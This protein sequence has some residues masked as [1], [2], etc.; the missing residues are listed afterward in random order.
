MP[1]RPLN[2]DVAAA[3]ADEWGDTLFSTR[4]RDNVS[5]AE[6]PSNG[7]DVFSHK[8]AVTAQK[9][10][11]AFAAEFLEKGRRDAMGLR[12]RGKNQVKKGS[13]SRLFARTEPG[14]TEEIQ[15]PINTGIQ[16]PLPEKK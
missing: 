16:E 9:D 11:A 6:A 4:I 3:L 13:P 1:E 10:Y 2:K 5:L 8:E 12:D 14:I 15:N 7:Q